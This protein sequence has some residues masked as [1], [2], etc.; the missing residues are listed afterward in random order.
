MIIADCGPAP[1]PQFGSVV[2]SG[3]TYGHSATYSCV[4]GYHIVGLGTRTCD[5]SSEWSGTTPTCNPV[6]ELCRSPFMKHLFS[7]S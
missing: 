2:T 6:G 4:E 5:Q 3:T 1:E 7:G